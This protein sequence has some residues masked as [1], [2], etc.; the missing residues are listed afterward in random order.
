MVA[1]VAGTKLERL[2]KVLDKIDGA[3]RE[4]VEEVTCDWSDIRK[5]L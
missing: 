1:I 2:R 5:R 4:A 3:K